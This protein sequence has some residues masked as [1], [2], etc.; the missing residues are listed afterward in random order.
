MI[1]D[2]PELSVTN[3]TVLDMSECFI[4]T[5]DEVLAL[6]PTNGKYSQTFGALKW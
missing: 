6:C 1:D 5:D 2:Y 4:I 3:L